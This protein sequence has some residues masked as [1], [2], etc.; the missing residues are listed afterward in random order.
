MFVSGKDN[1]DNCPLVDLS[2]A[3]EVAAAGDDV[4]AAVQKTKDGVSATFRAATREDGELELQNRYFKAVRV[5][6]LSQLDKSRKLLAQVGEVGLQWALDEIPEMLPEESATQKSIE[7]AAAPACTYIC[8]R[9]AQGNL[10]EVTAELGPPPALTDSKGDFEISSSSSERDLQE[11]SSEGGSMPS[12]VTVSGLDD[13]LTTDSDTGF[14]DLEY[15]LS[16]IYYSNSEEAEAAISAT[17]AATFAG[18]EESEPPSSVPSS[19]DDDKDAKDECTG[20]VFKTAADW[21]D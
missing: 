18:S 19:E 6:L 12:L 3:E 16:S 1:D 4:S 20:K 11:D 14:D 15:Q 10:E 7:L 5:V 17:S 8:D 13:D 21:F 9:M 2:L